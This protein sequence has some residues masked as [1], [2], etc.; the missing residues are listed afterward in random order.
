[1]RQHG[2]AQ[3]AR[4]VHPQHQY[5]HHDGA[6]DNPAMHRLTVFIRDTANGG[7]RQANHP[8]TDQ[9]PEGG[10]KG[11][12]QDIVC[13]V[14]RDQLRINLLQRIDGVMQS[15][16]SMYHANQQHDGANQHH[17][18]LHG[19]VEH[20]SAEAAEG[21]V[22]RNGDAKDQQAVLIL[23]AR[24][25]L[26]QACAADKLHRNRPDESNQQADT[27]NPH[28]RAVL[29]ARLQHVIEGNRVIASCQ[30]GELLTEYPQRQPDR[31][32]LD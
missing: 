4:Q 1:M 26:Q 16:S 3:R 2:A 17:H 22:Q 25:R 32:H 19:V 7:M 11:W 23:N 31:R 5:R 20:A 21:G 10:H 6:D 24:C 13:T 29:V 14:R 30:N 12:R 9:H 15:A 28:H 27:G 8:K 18:T